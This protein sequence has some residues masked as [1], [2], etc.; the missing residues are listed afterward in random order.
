MQSLFSTIAGATVRWHDL[1][2]PDEDATAVANAGIPLHVVPNAGHSMSWEN[3]SAL[4]A[5]LARIFIRNEG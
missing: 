5:I 2:V 1:P 4:A 3:P